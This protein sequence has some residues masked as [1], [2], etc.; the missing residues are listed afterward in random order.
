MNRGSTVLLDT[1]VVIEAVRINRWKAIAGGLTLETVKECE[2]EM[3][4]GKRWQLETLIPPELSSDFSA[5]HEVTED[6]RAVLYARSSKA[7]SI[8]AG[9]RDLLAHALSRGNSGVW[10]LASPDKAAI[11]AAVEAGIA[12]QLVSLEEILQCVGIATSVRDHFKSNWLRHERTKARLG[13]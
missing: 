1:N 13:G 11:G 3:Y 7:L 2:S 6:E 9:E 4:S 10:V 8:D 5:I 12:D